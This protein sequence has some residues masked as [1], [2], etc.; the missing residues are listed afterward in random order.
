MSDEDK[1]RNAKGLTSYSTLIH[2]ILSEGR[3]SIGGSGSVSSTWPWQ[4]A[5]LEGRVGWRLLQELCCFIGICGDVKNG[6]RIAELLVT[7][8]VL[9]HLTPGEWSKHP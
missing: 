5:Y 7:G 8:L 1:L 4:K 9:L 3:V 2:R 6:L